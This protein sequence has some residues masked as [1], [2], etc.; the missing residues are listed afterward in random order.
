[1]KILGEPFTNEQ[2]GIAVK[3]TNTDMMEKINASLAKIKDSGKYD[4]IFQKWFGE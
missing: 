4:E 3:K 1:M 2:Y